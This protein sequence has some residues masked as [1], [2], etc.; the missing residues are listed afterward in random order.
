MGRAL[1][2]AANVLSHVLM[3]FSGLAMLFMALHTAAD[4]IAKYFFN[5]PI[6]G[7]TE[8]I[9]YYYMTAIIFLGISQ[10]QLH[11]NHISVELFTKWLGLKGEKRVALI[12]NLIMFVYLAIIA[13]ATFDEAVGRTS[14]RE[15]VD[16][17]GYALL[18]IWPA[19]WVAPLGYGL[20]ALIC[21]LQT[22]GWMF[23]RTEPDA[24]ADIQAR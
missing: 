16:T 17:T 2:R 9:A 23:E 3:W 6:N 15:F 8:W 24:L 5:A 12:A 7:T 22:F 14:V 19:R 18:P 13:W 10:V 11:Q 20:A 1:A 4:V 21:L